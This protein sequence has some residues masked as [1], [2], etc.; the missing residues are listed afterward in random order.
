[1]FVQIC[2]HILVTCILNSWEFSCIACKQLCVPICYYYYYCLHDVHE[3]NVLWRGDIS[4]SIRLGFFIFKI[5]QHIPII[6][7]SFVV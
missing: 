2:F 1:M 7:D 5:A 6:S 4:A 3:M